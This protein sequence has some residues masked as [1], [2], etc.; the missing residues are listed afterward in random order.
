ME[1][2]IEKIKSMIKEKQNKLNIM[3]DSKFAEPLIIAFYQGEITALR[4]ILF[5]LIEQTIK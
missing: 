4:E 5:L 2:I 3:C 1:H